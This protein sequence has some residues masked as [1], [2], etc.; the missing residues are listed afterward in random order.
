MDIRSIQGWQWCPDEVSSRLAVSGA[1]GLVTVTPYR[2]KDLFPDAGQPQQWLLADTELFL[3]LAESLE[4][5]LEMAES[6]AQELALWAT[7]AHRFYPHQQPR[8]WAFLPSPARLTLS[9]GNI[10]E[11]QHT[12]GS[13]TFLVVRAEE[14]ASLLMLLDDNLQIEGM[15]PLICGAVLRVMNDRVQRYVRRHDGSHLLHAV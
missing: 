2:L 12:A 1:E 4:V 8:S 5:S 15:R 11:L 6:R 3:D 7:A 10:V 13:V 9:S 14:T